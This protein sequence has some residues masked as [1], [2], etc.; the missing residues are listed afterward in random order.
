[1][2][3]RHLFIL[4]A[5][6]WIVALGLILM[7]ADFFRHLAMSVGQATAIALFMAVFGPF[8]LIL[9]ILTGFFFDVRDE[10]V[11][12]AQLRQYLR[13]RSILIVLFLFSMTLF[14]ALTFYGVSFQR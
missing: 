5:L 14:V 12:M 10:D 1:M 6:F 7:N 4:Y 8:F 3:R 2:K 13:R 9:Y 11:T